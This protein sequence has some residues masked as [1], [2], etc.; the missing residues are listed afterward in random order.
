MGKIALVFEGKRI[1][2]DDKDVDLLKKIQAEAKSRDACCDIYDEKTHVLGKGT[3]NGV[4][5]SDFFKHILGIG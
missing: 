1:E 2:L 5:L 3:P 4:Q